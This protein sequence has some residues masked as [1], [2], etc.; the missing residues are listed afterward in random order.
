MCLSVS[1][2]VW[3]AARPA[4]SMSNPASLSNLTSR[5]LLLVVVVVAVSVSLITNNRQALELSAR[6]LHKPAGRPLAQTNKLARKHGKA[7]TSL[8]TAEA[9]IRSSGRGERNY[10]QRKSL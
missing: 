9:I 1:V 5:L 4:G 8:P 7:T 6:N 10:N 2:T 3:L